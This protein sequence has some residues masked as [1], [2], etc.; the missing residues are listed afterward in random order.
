MP[1]T[2]YQ[3]ALAD[4]LDGYDWL[5]FATFTSGHDKSPDSW[6]RSMEHLNAELRPERMFW[7]CEANDVRPHVHALIGPLGTDPA[8]YCIRKGWTAPELL[9]E[10]NPKMLLW[11]FAAE[12]NAVPHYEK[13]WDP[14]KQRSVRRYTGRTL[15]R[16]DVQD[17]IPRSGGRGAAHYVGKYV[18]KELND[19]DLFRRSRRRS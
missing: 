6:R 3:D 8:S 11:R 15:G 16:T 5:Y 14:V 7:G 1:L 12:S 17:Y 19:Y 18:T 10:V 2:R 13:I 9:E 4:W